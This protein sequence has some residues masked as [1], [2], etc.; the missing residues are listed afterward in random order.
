MAKNTHQI[1]LMCSTLELAASMG[2]AAESEQA[3]RESTPTTA[4]EHSRL[5]FFNP[6]YLA[7]AGPEIFP[8]NAGL[9]IR[10]GAGSGLERGVCAG[11]TA[12][13]A[14]DCDRRGTASMSRTHKTET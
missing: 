5:S 2:E 11:G 1:R 3:V 10:R 13:T 7:A 8:R 4:A 9:R 6:L 12:L 14:R